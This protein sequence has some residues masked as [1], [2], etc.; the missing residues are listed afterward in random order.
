MWNGQG[1]KK[2]DWPSDEIMLGMFKEQPTVLILDEFQTWFEG[3]TKTK[4]YP[5]RDWAFAFIRMLSEIAQDNPE[6]LSLVV[7]VRD[8]GSDADLPGRR[9]EEE[10]GHRSLVRVRGERPPEERGWPAAHRRRARL[11]RQ[12]QEFP[13]KG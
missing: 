12:A 5:W 11:S 4:Q 8:G 7:S 6:L 2:T 10:M 1:D 9:L 13:A 3:L